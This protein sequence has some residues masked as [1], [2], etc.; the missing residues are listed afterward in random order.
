MTKILIQPN[1]TIDITI[2][3]LQYCGSALR[4]FESIVKA[5]EVADKKMMIIKPEIILS[6]I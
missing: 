5:K 4:F 2:R 3:D 6:K 1:E